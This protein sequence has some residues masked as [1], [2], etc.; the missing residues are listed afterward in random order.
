LKQLK[1]NKNEGLCVRILDQAFQKQI[2]DYP[3][4]VDIKYYRLEKQD[5][6]WER[7][8]KADFEWK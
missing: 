1:N 7:E 2:M 8:I 4:L 5:M 3:G 6:S